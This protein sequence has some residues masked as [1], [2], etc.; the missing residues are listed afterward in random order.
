M[1]DD[2]QVF[3]MHENANIAFQQ[4]ES[5]SMISTILSI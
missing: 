4:Q 3:G 1:A 5:D 2:P